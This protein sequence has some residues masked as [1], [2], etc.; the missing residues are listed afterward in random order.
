MCIYFLRRKKTPPPQADIKNRDERIKNAKGIFDLVV[1]PLSKMV[2]PLETVL[3]IDD[4]STTGS[5]LDEAAKI[6]K[7]LGTEKVI[8][9]VFARG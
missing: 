5:T 6:L 1:E 2:Q 3:L 7:S 8:G 9:V 4:L